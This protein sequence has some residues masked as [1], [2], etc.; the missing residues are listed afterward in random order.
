M[1]WAGFGF[2]TRLANFGL[3]AGPFL[4]AASS[5]SARGEA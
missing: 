4:G 3:P 5:T 1:S 2:L